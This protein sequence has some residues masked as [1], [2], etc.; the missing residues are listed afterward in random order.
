MQ[1]TTSIEQLRNSRPTE[2]SANIKYNEINLSKK[3]GTILTIKS[4]MKLHFSLIR[5]LDFEILT[6]LWG[7]VQKCSVSQ[8]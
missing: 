2:M 1:G 3:M 4:M 5:A 6:H 8:L 7:G